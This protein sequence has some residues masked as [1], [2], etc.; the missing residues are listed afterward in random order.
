MRVVTSRLHSLTPIIPKQVSWTN[1]S[2]RWSEWGAWS[3]LWADPAWTSRSRAQN[4]CLSKWERSF[5]GSV[6]WRSRGTRPHNSGTVSHIE[7][8]LTTGTIRLRKHLRTWPYTSREGSTTPMFTK[9]SV[10]IGRRII[11]VDT[12]ALPFDHSRAEGCDAFVLQVLLGCIMPF[13]LE[14]SKMTNGTTSSADAE[15]VQ[16]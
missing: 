9:T 1:S 3:P 5:V 13:D 14:A 2:P 4:G 11:V 10:T 6:L 16:R 12:M 8:T 7:P 15:A